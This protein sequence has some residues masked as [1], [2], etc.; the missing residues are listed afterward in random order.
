MHQG[1]RGHIGG[2]PAHAPG[3][4]NGHTHGHGNLAKG[5]GD[6]WTLELLLV[7]GSWI[8]GGRTL[9]DKYLTTYVGALEMLMKGCTACYDLTAEFPLPT[10]EGLDACAQAYRDAGMRAVVAPMVAEYSFYESIPGLLEMLPPGLQARCGTLPAGSGGCLAGQY[11]SMAATLSKW[12]SGRAGRGADH[13]T[14]L[15]RRLHVW[16]RRP[17]REF[18]VGLA[19][20]CAGI[21]SPG[22][23][24]PQ[25][26]WRKPRPH[27]SG[28]RSPRAGLHRRTRRMA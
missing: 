24:Q 5:M 18:G 15:Q 2:A 28:A 11:A 19:Q 23:C 26:L 21:Q 7:A 20:P 27:T 1:R 3:L 8:N 4:I 14:S 13:P 22:H 10:V 12:R 25:A 17:S 16:L 9:E 6:R